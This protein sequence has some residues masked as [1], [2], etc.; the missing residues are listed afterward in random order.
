M[1]V[2]VKVGGSLAAY[3]KNLKSLCTKL[4]EI[5]KKQKLLIVP[6]GGEFAD[7]VRNH[8]K[9]FALSRGASHRM[10]ILGMDQ[11][12]LLLSDL[13][14]NSCV[15][16]S[17]EEA[18]KAAD[19]GKV[20]VFLPFQL[21]LNEDPLENSWDVTSDSIAVYIAGKIGA[22]KVLLITDVDGIFT[23]DP[24]RNSAAKMIKE[25]SASELL[26]RKRTSVDK[27]LPK[28]LL[29]LSID[30]FVINGLFAERVEAVLDGRDAIFTFIKSHS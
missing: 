6:G 17:L 15:V 7:T 29:E 26:G 25:V 18:K 1:S 30:C 13:T 11:Y 8:D 3:P 16:C 23:D 12:G 4:N 22:G 24:K 27:F 2:V 14:P 20:P 19:V 5:A 9:K 10:A 28:L 21:M